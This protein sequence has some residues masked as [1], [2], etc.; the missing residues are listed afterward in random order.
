[1]VRGEGEWL[2]G[3]DENPACLAA[4]AQL[5]AV[6]L[7]APSLRRMASSVLGERLYDVSYLTGQLPARDSV[8][9]VQ[10]DLLL[11]DPEFEVWLDQVGELDAVILWFTGIHKARAYSRLAREL[12]IATNFTHRQAVEDR[13]IELAE[14]RLRAG[15][16]LHIVTRSANADLPALRDDCAQYM[17]DLIGDRPFDLIGVQA[18]TYTEP[19]RGPRLG[20]GSLEFDATSMMRGVVSALIQKR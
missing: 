19:K 11:R 1:M 5:L 16:W 8:N 13:T 3:I 18:R 6:P 10:T 15:G 12:E 2:I 20:V 4:A 7:E 9:L 17:T 14:R